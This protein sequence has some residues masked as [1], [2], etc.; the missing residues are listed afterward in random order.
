MTQKDGKKKKPPISLT[1]IER[2]TFTLS[3]VLVLIGLM[4]LPN[5][6]KDSSTWYVLIMVFVLNAVLLVWILARIIGRWR[7]DK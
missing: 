5:V 7:R 3:L 1:L 6:E 2:N 4:C